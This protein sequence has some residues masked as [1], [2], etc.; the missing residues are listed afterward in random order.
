MSKDLNP[1]KAL[2]FRIV[3]RDNIGP[4]L[5]DGCHCR[6]TMEGKKYI[7][8]G[9]PELIQKR[10]EKAVPSGPGGT[11]SDYVPFYFTPYSPMLYNIKT[12]YNGIKQRPMRD[13]LILV[14]SLRHL[15]KLE[16]P[17]VF[18][19]RHA[20]LRMAQFSDDLADLNWIIWPTLQA[21]DFKRD[22]VD[23]FEKYQ[24]EALVYKHVPLDAL[25]GIV[26]YDAETKAEIEAAAAKAGANAKVLA[27]R[28]WFL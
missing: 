8:I 12:G 9:N 13:I 6:A 24:A 3:H 19:D 16:V 5:A 25:L 10:T 15:A 17:F 23:K 22:D 18:T 27:E 7:E 14:S 2:I 4:V 28:R 26:C 20:Y 11:L 1:E 21:R